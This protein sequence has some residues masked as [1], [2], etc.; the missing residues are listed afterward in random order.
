M[1]KAFDGL[2]TQRVEIGYT[3]GGNNSS[4][5]KSGELIIRNF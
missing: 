5:K 1:R 2:E 3:V 4:N